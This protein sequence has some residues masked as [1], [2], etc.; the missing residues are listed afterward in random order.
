MCV[1]VHVLVRAWN[2][3]TRR[4][5]SNTSQSANKEW[6]HEK[7]KDKQ[8]ESTAD[9]A[10]DHKYTH[11]E[12]KE[13]EY[14]GDCI[15]SRETTKS[16]LHLINNTFIWGNHVLPIIY[17]H[18]YTCTYPIEKLLHCILYIDD[19]IQLG[20]LERRAR[21]LTFSTDIFCFSLILL[22]MMHADSFYSLIFFEIVIVMEKYTLWPK[23]I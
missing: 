23:H 16:R 17:I 12:K 21:S 5:K 9:F 2:L 3:C 11:W 4:T 22:W 13:H 18:P 8:L 1:S 14:R 6:S 10:V 19:H 15:I 20:A 7:A